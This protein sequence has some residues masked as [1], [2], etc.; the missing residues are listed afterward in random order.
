MENMEKLNPKAKTVEIGKRTLKPIQIYPLSFTDQ[1]E[2]ATLLVGA[3]STV[4]VTWAN[5]QNADIIIE[6]K[7]MLQNNISLILE[8]VIDTEVIAINVLL[9]DITNDQLIDI[10]EIIWE[11]NFED[12]LER[13]GKNLWEKMSKAFRLTPSSPQFLND[14]V[15]QSE[16]SA[17]ALDTEV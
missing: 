13:K 6:A 1:S 7:D 5:K 8:K 17:E 4:V 10:I 16:P 11:V 12:P 14:T 9:N 15:S 2:V 3:I